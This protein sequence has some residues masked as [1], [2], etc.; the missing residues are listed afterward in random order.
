MTD[1]WTAANGAPL[2][3]T[4]AL[5]TAADIFGRPLTP[6]PWP[7]SK[8]VLASVVEILP[9]IKDDVVADVVEYLHQPVVDLRFFLQ[10]QG[11]GQG[12]LQHLREAVT[13]TPTVTTTPSRSTRP[14]TRPRTRARTRARWI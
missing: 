13:T 3:C 2:I 14:R 5:L 1:S 11:Q 9:T 4:G 10:A 12:Q 8:A 6:T 7:S